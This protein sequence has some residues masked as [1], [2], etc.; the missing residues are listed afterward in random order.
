[1]TELSV[2]LISRNQEWN[3]ARLVESVL[4][5]TASLPSTEIV[6]V[7]SVSTDRTP[8]IA[9]RYPITVLRLRPDQRQTAAAGRY[10]GYKQ[11]TGDLVLFLDGDMELCQG[12]LEQAITVMQSRSE[13]GVVCGPVID[14]PIAP[15]KQADEP[16]EF[17][18]ADVAGD[19]VLQGGG[20]AMYRRSVLEQ[21]G[22]WNPYLYSEEEPELCLRIRY[23]G[24][25]V[26]R[27]ARPI[28]FHY[29][30]PA[31]SI[32]TLFGRRSRNLWLGF[33]QNI[34]YFL[35]SP[36][37]WPY[38]RERG[39]AV[40]PALALTA[41]IIAT[42]ASGLT[43]HWGWLGLWVACLSLLTIG[44]AIRKCSLKRGV[45]SVF[46]R[47]LVL[48]GTIRGLLLKPFDPAGYAGSYEV[49]T[50]PNC[51]LSSGSKGNIS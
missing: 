28:V 50:Q 38:L 6:L 20:A 41:G 18:E 49:M 45:F 48:E 3:I 8:K 29:S 35:G 17:P 47:L 1:M 12:W 34:R 40:A 21:V 25:R 2:V 23:A 36:L 7:D 16:A 39:W 42:M 27:L 26:L 4:R 31:D 5:E 9:A 11:T 30:A 14:R 32:S 44:I 19:E 10:V 37:L 51:Q 33:G 13:V 24:Y 15:L 43:G 46:Q 22:T